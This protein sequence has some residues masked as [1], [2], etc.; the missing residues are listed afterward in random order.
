[1]KRCCALI[2]LLLWAPALSAQQSGQAAPAPQEGWDTSTTTSLSLGQMSFN[3]N[4]AAGGTDVFSANG[5]VHLKINHL[6]VD[7]NGSTKTQFANTVN[8]NYGIL[9]AEGF[10][11]QKSVDDL[12]LS[13]I[14]AY[15]FGED[16]LFGG[17]ALYV[18]AMVSLYT[19]MAPGYITTY[20]DDQG[21]TAY[22]GILPNIVSNPNTGTSINPLIGLKVSSFMSPGYLWTRA[23]IRYVLQIEGIEDI[24]FQVAPLSMKQTYVLDGDIRLTKENAQNPDIVSAFDIYSTLGKKLTT[25]KGL[26]VDFNLHLPL[27]VVSAALKNISLATTNVLFF[28]Y[29]DPGFD[30]M[31]TFALQGQ[32]NQYISANLTS[33]IIY[34][35]NTDTDFSQSGTQLGLQS[36]G[37]LGIGLTLKF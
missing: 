36:M 11:A 17:D 8:L 35:E 19:Q 14:I 37:N 12:N 30:V 4:W 25:S 15:R 23:G 28:S 6:T 18:G 24:F 32:I 29:K 21:Q 1:M 13:S 10:S 7:T 22:Y 9:R 26:T 33:T 27:S 3:S 5:N 34:N 31:S 16:L 2:A 20:V